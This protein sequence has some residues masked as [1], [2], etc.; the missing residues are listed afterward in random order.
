MDI[1]RNKVMCICRNITYGQIE[2]A[3]YSGLSNYQQVFNKL[4]FGVGCGGCRSRI[5]QL[6]YLIAEERDEQNEH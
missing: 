3:V 4:R 6:I 2:D 1:E 5:K